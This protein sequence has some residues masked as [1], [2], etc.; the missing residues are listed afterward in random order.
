MWQSKHKF[1]KMANDLNVSIE[2]PCGNISAF[3]ILTAVPSPIQ[4]TEC[5]WSIISQT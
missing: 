3:V 1:P 2:H 5:S 4:P